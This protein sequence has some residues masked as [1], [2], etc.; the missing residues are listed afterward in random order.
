MTPPWMPIAIAELARGV[1]E[2]PGPQH[3]QRILAY[4]ATTTL[5]ARDD[6]TPWC[7]S[8][9]NWCIEQAGLVGTKSAAARSWMT[10]GQPVTVSEVGDIVVLSRVG[11]QHVGFLI[12][13]VGDTL[14]LLAGNQGNRVSVAPFP[15]RRIM[16][17]RRG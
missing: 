1:N 4:H 9:V 12:A 8:F 16:A 15:L 10:W 3:N 2:L 17:V 6:E 11:G 5:D 13:V 7:S 14:L